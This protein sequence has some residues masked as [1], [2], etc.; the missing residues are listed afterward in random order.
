MLNQFHQKCN[1]RPYMIYFQLSLQENFIFT[2]VE[3][4]GPESLKSYVNSVTI[5]EFLDFV[6]SPKYLII[7]CL[8]LL[9]LEFTLFQMLVYGDHTFNPTSTIIMACES[10]DL[11]LSFD[12]LVI[13]A[14]C[15][16][17]CW[18]MRRKFLPKT[19]H[20]ISIAISE[21]PFKIFGSPSTSNPSL[22]LLF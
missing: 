5:K 3:K 12:T 9:L 7:L 4:Q 20:F 11:K 1:I 17:G 21:G 10:C 13:N 6:E 19:S 8:N 2:L 18:F 15:L 14:Q 16:G 22:S